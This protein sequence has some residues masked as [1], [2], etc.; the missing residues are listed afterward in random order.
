MKESCLKW[1]CFDELYS[2]MESIRVI[3]THSHHPEDKFF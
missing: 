2:Y 1:T 3:N